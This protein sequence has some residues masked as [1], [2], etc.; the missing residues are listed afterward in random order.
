MKVVDII[1][2]KIKFMLKRI[3]QMDYKAMLQTVKEIHKKAKKPQFVLFFDIIYCGF[4]Y[5]AGYKDYALYEFYNLTKAQRA[6]YIVRTNNNM[7]I[8]HCN[9]RN[10]YHCLDNKIEFNEKYNEFLKRDWLDFKNASRED[11]NKFIDGKKAIIIKP[12][13]TCCGAGVE[14]MVV[15][16]YA[17]ND[18]IYAK[19]KTMPNAQL[20]EDYIIQHHVLSELYSG[21]VNSCRIMTLLKNDTVHIIFAALKIGNNGKVVDNICN[22]GICVPIDIETGKITK[23][24]YDKK[25][26]LYEKHPMT[27]HEIQGV[28]IPHWDAV[29]D[30]CKRAA[31]ITPQVRYCGWDVAIREDCP[32][33]IEGNQIPE[34]SFMQ[35]PPHTPDKIGMLPYYRN[36][37]KDEM[38]I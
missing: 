18:E 19:L 12:V 2:R 7:I 23:L 33:L 11:F 26:I 27:G 3:A 16:N 36:L 37:L 30:L 25:G 13:D 22:G 21:S 38:N 31:K 29:I 8:A 6:T 32:V 24:A 20:L 5:G 35:L 14:K 17:N 28:Q 4:K 1:M 9:D 34:Y 15:S 10:Y